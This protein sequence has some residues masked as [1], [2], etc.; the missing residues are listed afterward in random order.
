[1]LP[2]VLCFFVDLRQALEFAT[3]EEF[4]LLLEIPRESADKACARDGVNRTM[5][6]QRSIP[7]ALQLSSTMDVGS[8][9]K[10]ISRISDL[11]WKKQHF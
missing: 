9:E 7:I 3:M 1:M 5:H 6:G 2:C 10:R 8:L 4:L 11:K